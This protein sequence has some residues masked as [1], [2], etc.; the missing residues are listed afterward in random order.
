MNIR[1]RK[2]QF[3]YG[4][5]YLSLVVVPVL[6]YAIATRPGPSCVD[7]KKNQGETEIDC[8]GPCAKCAL[9]DVQDI[10]VIWKNFFPDGNDQVV[11]GAKI[12]NPNPHI[13][14]SS[15][16]YD[17]TL[18]GPFGSTIGSVSGN[19][20]LFPGQ[21]KYIIDGPFLV[22]VKGVTDV[23]L[24][25]RDIQ[26]VREEEMPSKIQLSLKS[27]QIK[28]IEGGAA[29]E[30]SGLV[31][32]STA[33]ALSRVGVRVVIP[34]RIGVPLLAS[35][36]VLQDV[37]SNEERFFRIVIPGETATIRNLDLFRPDIEAEI[38]P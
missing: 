22:S 38:L 28:P 30:V 27:I 5:V 32:N 33:L 29:V 24:S 8:G 7:K 1:R 17:I 4:L 34:D 37:A 15:F 21:T 13:G 19:A 11:A 25:I 6:V 14:V 12:R 16:A 3:I 9:K 31:S 36:T 26:W 18:L 2:K 35:K 10:E 20:Q 23:R